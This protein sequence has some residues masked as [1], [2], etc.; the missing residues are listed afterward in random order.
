MGDKT[1][2]P[3][4]VPACYLRAWA[5]DQ[6]QVAVHR[7]SSHKPFTP[8]V[9]NVAVE[10]GLYGMGAVGQSREN[11]FGQIETEWP[12]TRDAL[13][14]EGGGVQGSNRD[15][16]SLFAALQ[17]IRTREHVASSQFL[18]DFAEFSLRRPVERDDV[19][20]FLTERHLRFAPSDSEVEGAWTIA[21][22]SLNQ[23]SL[24]SREETFA[25]S[26]D[27]AVTQLAPRLARMHWSVEHCRK[28]MLFTSDRPVMSWRLPT[29]RDR[30]EG[31]GI[32]TAQEVRFPITP[33]EL[34]VMRPRGGATAIIEVQPKRF[35]RVNQD[36]AAQC[37]EFVVATRQRLRQLELLTLAPHRPVLRFDVGPGY[38]QLPDGRS[39]PMGDI[40]H[41]WVPLRAANGGVPRRARRSA[42][43]RSSSGRSPASS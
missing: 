13:R 15:L 42:A 9:V 39:E 41:S 23:G 40:V 24:P 43:P 3:H 14:S 20:R 22:V 33:A 18:H 11:L 27:V 8:N 25:R 38:R 5:D 28:P 7:R 17:L 4:Y 31:I 21:S 32:E 26:L 29:P 12:S 34:L 37:H 1:K 16:V 36:I 30:I 10:A 2:R 35:E 19:R 6:D